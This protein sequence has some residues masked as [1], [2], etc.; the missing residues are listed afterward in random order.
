MDGITFVTNKYI[1]VPPIIKINNKV[2]IFINNLHH[3]L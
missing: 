1:N 3:P 2:N